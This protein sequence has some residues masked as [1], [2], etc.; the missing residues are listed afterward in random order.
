[1]KHVVI[2]YSVQSEHAKKS[3]L[4]KKEGELLTPVDTILWSFEEKETMSSCVRWIAEAEP[5]LW[6]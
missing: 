1:M 2:T 4:T 3:C 5:R 6:C